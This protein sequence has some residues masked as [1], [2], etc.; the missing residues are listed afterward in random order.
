MS[1]EKDTS[2]GEEREGGHRLGFV[3]KHASLSERAALSAPPAV[4]PPLAA[5]A[6][7]AAANQSIGKQFS[8]LSLSTFASPNSEPSGGLE[9]HSLHS[10]HA[11]L[12][13]ES[14]TSD[15]KACRILFSTLLYP[16]ALA[17]SPNRFN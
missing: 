8:F 13:L 15:P 5:S 2:T 7:V 10:K 9:E 17:F 12:A 6:T 1:E 4:P 11:H 3:K 14:G 16:I